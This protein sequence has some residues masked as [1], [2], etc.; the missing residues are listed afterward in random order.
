MNVRG[1]Q[2]LK[3][4]I[5]QSLGTATMVGAQALKDKAYEIAEKDTGFMAESIHIVGV[6]YSEY[7]EA[8]A[9]AEI[10][11]AQ[12]FKLGRTPKGVRISKKSRYNF[13]DE[14]RPENP[15]ELWV[16][17]GAVHGMANEEGHQGRKPFMSPAVATTSKVFANEIKT[18]YSGLLV[19]AVITKGQTE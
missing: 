10:L 14:V 17:V 6:D 5:T 13:F 16:V 19:K 1:L 15:E 3:D 9:N 18:I 8:K 11:S 2:V 12:A 4:K 7:A